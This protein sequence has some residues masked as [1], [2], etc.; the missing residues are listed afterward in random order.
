MGLGENPVRFRFEQ[1]AMDGVSIRLIINGAY[2]DEDIQDVV[3]ESTTI[4]TSRM[5]GTHLPS[6]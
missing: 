4:G 6:S 3:T 5:A 1:A 2:L